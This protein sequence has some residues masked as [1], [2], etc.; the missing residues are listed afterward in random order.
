MSAVGG[1]RCLARLFKMYLSKQ[2]DGLLLEEKDVL[3]DYL[4]NVFIKTA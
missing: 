2:P 3:L 4:K 1:E